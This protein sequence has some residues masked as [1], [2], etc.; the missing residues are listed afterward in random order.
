MHQS[1]I[2]ETNISTV[3]DNNLN[4]WHHNFFKYELEITKNVSTLDNIDRVVYF[5]DCQTCRAE[6]KLCLAWG[7]FIIIIA[8]NCPL[9]SNCTYNVWRR[10]KW[11]KCGLL[12]VPTKNLAHCCKFEAK[13]AAENLTIGKVSSWQDS[14]W[15]FAN[16]CVNRLEA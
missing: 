9:Q 2:R 8:W 1:E 16:Q 11:H 15:L 12:S 6:N 4:I 7:R 3:G 5:G 10:K 13:P 14:Y